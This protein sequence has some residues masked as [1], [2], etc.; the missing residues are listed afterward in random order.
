MWYIFRQPNFLS[1][2]KFRLYGFT[3]K[4]IGLNQYTRLR[5]EARTS[6]FMT[7][8]KHNILDVDTMMQNV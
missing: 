6:Y 1:D 2:R 3:S 7:L 5:R 4:V 8:W